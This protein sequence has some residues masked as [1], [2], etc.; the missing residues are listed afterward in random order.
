MNC[1]PDDLPVPAERPLVMRAG[2]QLF[3]DN[4][5][6]DIDGQH[7]GTTTTTPERQQAWL[8][9]IGRRIKLLSDTDTPF[10]FVL[11]PDK[12]SVYRHVLSDTYS[13]RQAHFLTQ[14]SCILD[15]APTLRA[16][17]PLIDVY[18]RTDSHWNQLGAIIAA[19]AVVAKLDVNLPDTFVSWRRED[20]PGDLGGKLSPVETSE[21]LVAIYKD[22]SQLIYDNGVPNNGRIRIFSKLQNGKSREGSLC[23]VFGDSFSYDLVHFLK[24][25]FDILVQVHSFALDFTLVTQ[26]RPDYVVAEMTERFTLRLPSPGDG[27]P[28]PALWLDKIFR[29]EKAIRITSVRSP[30]SQLHVARALD[31]ILQIERLYSPYRVFLGPGDPNNPPP[32]RFSPDDFPL[33]AILNDPGIA[34]SPDVIKALI[35]GFSAAMSDSE[36]AQFLLEFAYPPD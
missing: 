32:P 3:I 2:E 17:A 16:V 1:P 34:G 11:A 4:D 20:L 15:I 21:R 26:L 25:S 7:K 30:D 28:L 18:P 24:E 8:D 36:K 6:N 31:S 12:H 27:H 19:S 10:V 9:L 23:L 35:K 5:T 33:K 13:F 14:H 29:G 22:P